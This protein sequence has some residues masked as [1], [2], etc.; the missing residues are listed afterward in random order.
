MNLDQFLAHYGI[1]GMRWG[2]RKDRKRTVPISD[3]ARQAEEAKRKAK[4]GGTKALSNRELQ[5]LVTRLNLEQQYSR[6]NPSRTQKA[7]RF[8]R[9]LLVGVGKQQAIRVANDYAARQIS[10]L[11]AR[12]S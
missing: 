1:K 3:D 4:A 11:L 12:R 10:D 6:L 2:V 8:V 7:A 5:I 9:E